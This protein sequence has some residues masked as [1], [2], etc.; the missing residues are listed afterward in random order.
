[1]TISY[2]PS[3][4]FLG[5]SRMQSREICVFPV[6]LLRGHVPCNRFSFLLHRPR[7][8]ASNSS[9]SSFFLSFLFPLF[10]RIETR[11][12]FSR[13]FTREGR[14]VYVFFYEEWMDR[15]WIMKT[16]CCCPF[17]RFQ[18]FSMRGKQIS[19]GV[20]GTFIRGLKRRKYRY[21]ENVFRLEERL[22]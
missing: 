12:T 16:E 7:I 10:T 13:S 9:A 3:L 8:G 19:S 14:K 5:D 15:L 20:C 18:R 21:F 22:V 4:T 1:M 17:R 2:P 11:T 6:Y